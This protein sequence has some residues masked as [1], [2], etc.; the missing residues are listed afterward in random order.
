MSAGDAATDVALD[1]VDNRPPESRRRWIALTVVLVGQF[2]ASLD[3]TVG[4]VAAPSISRELH[5]S[6]GVAALAVAGYTLCYASMLITGARLGADR[7]RRRIF[8]LGIAIFTVTST[9]AGVAPNGVTLI[10]ARAAQGI[11][12]ALAI[13]QAISFIQADFSGRSR[14]RALTAYSVMIS[15]GASVG[16]AA[17]GLLITLDIAG[18]GWRTVFL[19]NLPVGVAVFAVAARMLPRIPPRP[20]HLDILGVALLTTGAALVAGPLAMGPNLGWPWP[21]WT[22]LGLG[23][24]GLAMFGYWQRA[25]R[26]RG[27]SPLLDPVILSVRGVRPGLAALLLSSTTY[28]GILYCVA[29]D[30]QDHHRADPLVAGLALVP[31]T[32]GFGAGS[33]LGSFVPQH[34]HRVLVIAGLAGL[35]GSLTLLAV[36]AHGGGWPPISAPL[37]LGVA[38]LGYGASFSP[39]IGITVENI[40]DSHIAEASG[41]STTT[42]QFSFVLGVA[43]FG[44]IYAA[45]SLTVA[46][47]SMGGLAAL[48]IAPMIAHRQHVSR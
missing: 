45:A 37:L 32:V 10:A 19:M 4:N 3:T 23:A 11:G 28:T 13:P 44:S 40:G 38:G 2:M 12:A 46:L 5:V 47:A 7:G 41:I 35:G 42:F 26:S 33:T 6:S 24:A 18:L 1:A 21:S 27:G 15:L 39:T 43:A 16:L 20:R 31:F 48:A 14:A 25:L 30:L 8:L 17:G 22:A 29:A 34:R 9:A 36:L